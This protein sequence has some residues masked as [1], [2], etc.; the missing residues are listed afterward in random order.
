MPHT[1]QTELRFSSDECPPTLVRPRFGGLN[2]DGL[3]TRC[4]FCSCSRPPRITRDGLLICPDCHQD[5]GH[6]PVDLETH[7]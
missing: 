3:E 2:L 5:V 4:R 1:P 6:V 7:Y